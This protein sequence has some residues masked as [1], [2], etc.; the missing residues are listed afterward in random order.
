MVHPLLRTFLDPP[1][2]YQ[3]GDNSENMTQKYWKG[4]HV[5][6]YLITNQKFKK[7]FL[8]IGEGGATAPQAT[9][10]NLLL[11]KLI[12]LVLLFDILQWVLEIL[13]VYLLRWY[14]VGK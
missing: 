12:F 10:L 14:N 9:V 2:H 7:N 3:T 13:L 5:K 8:R 11:N 6:Q 1:L 4:V